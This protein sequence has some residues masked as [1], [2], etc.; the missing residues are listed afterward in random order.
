VYGKSLC[1]FLLLTIFTAGSLSSSSFFIIIT[2]TMSIFII[3]IIVLFCLHQSPMDGSETDGGGGCS[4]RYLLEVILNCSLFTASQKDI[5]LCATF[6]ALLCHLFCCEP[7]RVRI[8]WGSK[9]V[10]RGGHCFL[11]NSTPAAYEG[12]QAYRCSSIVKALETVHDHS[13]MSMTIYVGS[14]CRTRVMTTPRRH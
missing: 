1:C 11:H 5:S 12:W 2:V 6:W 3:I 14:A 10:T 4:F 8:N 9:V 7:H 13:T